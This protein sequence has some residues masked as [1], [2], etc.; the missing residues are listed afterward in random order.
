M[1]NSMR[2]LAGQ[3]AVY[4][5]STVLVK[6]LNYILVPYL[7]RVMGQEAYGVVTH[8]YGIIPL[9]LVILTMGLESGYFRFAGKA[10]SHD[11]KQHVFATAWGIVSLA[12]ALFLALVLLFL[13]PVSR[14]I[15]YDTHP[16]FVWMTAAIIALD[17]FT[18]VPFA[19]LR[20]QQQAGRYVFLRLVS[21][22]VNL[23][24]CFFFYGWLPRLADSS[25]IFA[26]LYSADAGP[27]YV[28]AANLIAS[29]VTML[30]I[31][32]MCGRIY[33]KITPSLAR[34]ILLYSL[35]L[36]LSGIAG[37]A[38]EFIDRQ[39]VLCFIPGSPEEALQQLG[40]YGAVLRLGVVMTLFTS[41]YR[42]AAEPFFLAEFKGDDFRKT[43]AEA[44][45]YFVIVSIFIFLVIAL[46]SDLFAL[47]L[48]RDFRQG[49]HILPLIL[50][51]NMFS[52]IV[53]N[54][55]FWY[56]QSGAT[57]FA[58]YIT[59]LGLIFTVILNI[60]LVPAWGY[61]GAAV[62]RLVCEIAMVVF[63][64]ALNRKYCPVPYDLRRIGTYFLFGA[65]LYFAGISC[66]QLPLW[67]RYLICFALVVIFAL[68]SLKKEHI[69]VSGMV[70][71]LLARN[72]KNS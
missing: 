60:I 14:A 45:K 67:P 19:R 46:F 48:G 40:I 38:N 11:Q 58:I 20:E 10:D 54:L 27:G 13:N 7:T 18:A 23:L 72:S 64:Y 29:F 4:G 16:S 69:D 2:K 28:F 37:T 42:L 71:H 6:L 51:A 66:H 70:R 55:S 49:V 65:A 34:Q 62:A 5:V 52:G 15:G 31:I 8:I 33:P 61:T 35:P 22:V 12:S 21:V 68:C 17:A 56:K 36:L 47:I 39:M 1:S 30:L 53:L 63:S 26:S 59:G 43:N 50:L 32:P 25:G 3:T 24:F 9:A 41:M 57:R 44:M